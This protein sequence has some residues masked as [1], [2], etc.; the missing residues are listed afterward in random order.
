M[1]HSEKALPGTFV[2]VFGERKQIKPNMRTFC[3][4]QQKTGRNPFDLMMWVTPSPVDVVTLIWAALG[5]EDLGKTVDEVAD[6]LDFDNMHG[7]NEFLGKFFKKGEAPEAP[8]G[9]AAA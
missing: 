7:L 5:G 8:K 3:R 6:A 1:E 4:F 2:E 9:D